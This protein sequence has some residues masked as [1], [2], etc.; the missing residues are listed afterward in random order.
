MS[1][2]TQITGLKAIK[3]VNVV[4]KLRTEDLPLAC[5][6]P[7]MEVWDMHP[8]VY[9]ALNAESKAVCPYCNTHYYL[10]PAEELL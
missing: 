4:V 3:Q 10:A 7:P 1:N 8:K 6:M 9:L 5:P 2:T